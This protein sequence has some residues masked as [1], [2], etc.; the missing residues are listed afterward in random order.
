MQQA[1]PYDTSTERTV[2][3]GR[4]ADLLTLTKPRLNSL[5]LVTSAAA[6]YLGGGVELPWTLML[7]TMVGTA[8]V[9]AGAS[10]L[11]QVWERDTDRLMRRTA[12]RPLPDARMHPH[13]AWWFG[14]A[15][16]AVGIADLMLGVNALTAGIAVVTLA[17]YVL[18]YTPLKIRSTLSTIVGAVP[19]ALP[20]VIGWTAATNTLSIEAWV[21]FGIVFMWQMPHFLAIA[22]MFRDDYARA[23][24]PL[25]PV[26]QPD[27]RTTSH[28]AVLYAAALIPVSVMPTLIGL[29]SAYY[30][31]GAIVL[32]AMLL[33]L[34]VAFAVSRSMTSARRLFFGTI[35]YLPLL[36][37]ALL[38]DYFVHRV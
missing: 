8:L 14:I 32:G 31:I 30:L 29:T 18:L 25:L 3:R 4:A 11:N 5:V 37:V 16:S 6:Y 38:A 27:G 15:L 1:A 20:A 10:A 2:V 28:Q 23:G 17:T 22:W 24:I 9:A 26:I 36:W 34:C 12:S 33:G 35:L 19:G 21:L 13:D 7:H